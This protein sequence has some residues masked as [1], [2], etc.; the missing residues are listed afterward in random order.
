M[1]NR[2]RRPRY[3]V[4]DTLDSR[5]KTYRFGYL[6]IFRNLLRYLNTVSEED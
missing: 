1:M 3:R 2:S 5:E 6:I 4:E